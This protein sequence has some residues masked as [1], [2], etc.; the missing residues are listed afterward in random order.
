MDSPGALPTKASRKPFPHQRVRHP[1]G[2]IY[3]SPDGM[4]PP[5]GRR[6]SYRFSSESNALPTTIH[7]RSLSNLPS[8]G[9]TFEDLFAGRPVG[10]GNAKDGSVSA[11]F[12]ASTTMSRVATP[13]DKDAGPKSCLLAR[14]S[15]DSPDLTLRNPAD[16]VEPKH[17]G[18]TS[19]R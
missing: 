15:A 9:Q 4:G 12:A 1:A 7:A 6:R 17:G 2:Q 3:D 5:I 13:A 16:E 18:S 11:S 8:E 19:F 10:R 14:T